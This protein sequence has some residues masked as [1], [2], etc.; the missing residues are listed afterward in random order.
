MTL[1]EYV[2]YTRQKVVDMTGSWEKLLAAW[3]EQPR[4]EALLTQLTRASIYPEVLAEVLDQMEV[5][6]V[7]I[8]GHVAYDRALQ[9]RY[10]RILEMRQRERPWLNSFDREARE[11]IFALLGK[12]ELGGLRQIIDPRIF[13]VPPFRQMGEVRGVIRPR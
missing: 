2:N 5:D 7:D 8:L 10:D 4:R 13:R 12:Y 3:Q 9:T 6:E 1:Q 11:V